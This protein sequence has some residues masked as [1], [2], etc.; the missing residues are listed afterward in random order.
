MKYQGLT[1]KDSD[2]LNSHMIICLVDNRPEIDSMYVINVDILFLVAL[3]NK[4]H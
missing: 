3:S 4:P 2:S 1:F